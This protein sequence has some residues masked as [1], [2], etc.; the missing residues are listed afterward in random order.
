MS[1]LPKDISSKSKAR[2]FLFVQSDGASQ[3]K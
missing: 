3:L 2:S 1:E